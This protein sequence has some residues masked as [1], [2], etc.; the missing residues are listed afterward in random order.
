MFDIAFEDEERNKQIPWQNSWGMTTRTIGVMIM[1]HGDDKGLVLPPRVSPVQIVMVPVVSKNLGMEDLAREL[2][3][4]ERSLIQVGVRTRVDRDEH[5]TPGW[6]Y[7]F[8]EMK[9][10]PLRLELGPRDLEKKQVRLVRRDNGEKQD[11]PLSEVV[12]LVTELLE[13][14]QEDMLSK[15]TRE[16]DAALKQVESWEE[17][18]QV[19][20]DGMMALSPSCAEKACEESICRRS[21]EE[22]TKMAVGPGGGGG[23]GEDEEGPDRGG[24]QA[25]CIPFEQPPLTEGATCVGCAKAAACFVLYGRSY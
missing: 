5:R 4:I 1:V 15:A 10:V 3:D 14:I 8:W 19:V 9:G 13:R 24:A 7:N 17:M 21:K 12:A 22:A 23:K 16:R 11:V 25:L 20:R 6:K 18:C 2:T